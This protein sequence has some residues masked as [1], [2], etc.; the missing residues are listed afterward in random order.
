MY[1]FMMIFVICNF[2]FFLFGGVFYVYVQVKGVDFFVN[3]DGGV[4]IDC[5]F[6][7]LV[8]G[9]FG[10]LV[11]V[12]FLF[13]IIVLL[14]VFVDLVLIVLIIG[15]CIDFLNFNWWEECEKR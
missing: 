9:K 7:I 2:F 12:F 6:L 15:F 8:F 3:G 5:V 11:G 13:G 10:I 1:S 4:I 14:Y